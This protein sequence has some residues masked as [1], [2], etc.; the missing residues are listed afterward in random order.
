MSWK[1]TVKI[2]PCGPLLTPGRKV[3]VAELPGLCPRGGADPAHNWGPH[4][5]VPQ[6]LV[7]ETGGSTRT[8]AGSASVWKLVHG[9]LDSHLVVTRLCPHLST[10]S[11]RA[12]FRGDTAGLLEMPLS[13]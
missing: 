6:P 13:C 7:L 1:T 11:P 9:V 10:E 5:P 8:W 4:A 2:D 3:D 12:S